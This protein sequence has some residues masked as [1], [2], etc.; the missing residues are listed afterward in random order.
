VQYDKESVSK[1]CT[2]CTI[3]G[4]EEKRFIEE[5]EEVE[6]LETNAR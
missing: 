3:V 5:K 4:E 6:P 2:P 1:S